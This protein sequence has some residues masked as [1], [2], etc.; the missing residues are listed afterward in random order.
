MPKPVR[1]GVFVRP[2]WAPAGRTGTPDH[3]AAT[4]ALLIDSDYVTGRVIP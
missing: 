4:V 1:E 2:A 3:V